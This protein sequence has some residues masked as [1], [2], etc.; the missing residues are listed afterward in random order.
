MD[1]K[2]RIL[3][4]ATVLLTAVLLVAP[5]SSN[6]GMSWAQDSQES[7]QGMPLAGTWIA[8]IEDSDIVAWAIITAQNPEHTKFGQLWQQYNP[9]P[10]LSG[11]FPEADHQ[12]DW[13]GQVV[14]TGWNTYESCAIYYGTQKVEDQLRP[15]ILYMAVLYGE[16]R[17]VDLN[18][19]T[20]SGTFAVFLA[21]QDADGDGFPDEG[22]EPIYCG[23]YTFESCKRVQVMPPCVPPPPEGQ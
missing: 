9:D 23:T 14:Q 2:R 15:Q 10:T 19:F 8:T 4:V 6:A 21:E 17:L 12:S 7:W 18:S 11:M 13:V 1:A 16:G 22:E 3:I 5:W 20:A